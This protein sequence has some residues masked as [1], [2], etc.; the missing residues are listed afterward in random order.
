MTLVHSCAIL[1]IE[2]ISY[3]KSS[4]SHNLKLSIID[5]SLYGGTIVPRSNL[6]WVTRKIELTF[7]SDQWSSRCNGFLYIYFCP[8]QRLITL[9][10]TAIF[11]EHYSTQT[12]WPERLTWLSPVISDLHFAMGFCI[13]IFV[14]TNN[15]LLYVLQGYYHL[16]STIRYKIDGFLISYYIL[17]CYGHVTLC[18]ISKI[19]LVV[20]YQCCVLIGWVKSPFGLRPHGL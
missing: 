2:K 10:F 3:L 15:K 13:Y 14:P 6:Y 4:S 7:A 11:E 16:W 5:T 9:R 1:S 19:Q 8:H 20:Y 12:E 18:T 17:E